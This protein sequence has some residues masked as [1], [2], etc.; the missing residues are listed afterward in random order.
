MGLARIFGANVRKVR[1][2]KGLSIEA[3]A[4]EVGL[5]YTYLGQLERGQRNPSLAIVERIAA[6]LS[7]D[8]V[9]LLSPADRA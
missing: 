6:A 5:A 3:L 2:D 8:A 1:Q 7:A 4:H 9:E